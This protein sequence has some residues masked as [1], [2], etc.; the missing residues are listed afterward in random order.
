MLS[1]QIR[2]ENP[3]SSSRII[4]LVEKIN[5]LHIKETKLHNQK[6]VVHGAIILASVYLYVNYLNNW[7]FLRICFI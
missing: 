1:T 2:V 6:I 4:G 3:N 7:R 5:M